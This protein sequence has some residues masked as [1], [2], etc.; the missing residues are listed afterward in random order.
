MNQAAQSWTT[1]RLLNWTTERFEKLEMDHPRLCAEMLLSHV[2]G[3]QRIKL[4]MDQDRPSSDLERAAFRELVERAC[5]HEPVDYLVGPAPFY[6]LTFKVNKDVLIPRPSTETIIDHVIQHSRNTPGFI[7]PVIADIGTG[8]G[9]IAVTLAKNL[10]KAHIVATD[11]SAQALEVAKENATKMGVA[12]RIEFV[13]GHLL[14]PILKH[15]FE[16]IISNPPYIPDDEWD[17]VEANVKDYEPHNALRGGKDGLDLIRILIA[18][19]KK[20]A[21]APC[22]LLIEF[23]AAQKLDMLDLATQ[24]GWKNPYILADHEGFD[25]ILVADA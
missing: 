16:Y 24:H 4:Y 17:A 1:R 20:V 23:A 11:I 5:K 2:L 22:Q 6:G 21:N 7:E 15:R 9:T 13:H 25:R 10:P 8:S 14:E 3:V 12:E 19:A 18:D